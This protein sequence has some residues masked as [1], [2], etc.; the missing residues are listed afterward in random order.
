M[1]LELYQKS[2]THDPKVIGITMIG[3]VDALP[4]P[5]K[6]LLPVYIRFIDCELGKGGGVT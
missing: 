1:S 6:S 3:I 5:G 4:E 2:Q